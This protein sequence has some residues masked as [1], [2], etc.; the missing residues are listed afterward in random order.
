M[1]SKLKLQSLRDSK[2][3]LLSFTIDSSS[4]RR[5]TTIETRV[6]FCITAKLQ[7][8]TYSGFDFLTI[9]PPINDITN[10]KNNAKIICIAEKIKGEDIFF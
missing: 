8:L 4:L 2:I 9:R 6:E 7:N 10:P 5:G 3:Q 1:I